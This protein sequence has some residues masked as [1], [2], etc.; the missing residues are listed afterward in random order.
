[1]SRSVYV[2]AVA[3]EHWSGT[4]S[5]I[6]TRAPLSP[7]FPHLD[8]VISTDLSQR[9]RVLD[10]CSLGTVTH[11]APHFLPGPQLRL[12]ALVIALT[13]ALAHRATTC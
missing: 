10:T 3:R 13:F 12:T 7:Q 2:V 8:L 4:I 9:S 5:M 6:V 1:M 11:P